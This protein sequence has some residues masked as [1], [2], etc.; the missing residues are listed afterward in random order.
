MRCIYFNQ[1]GRYT[2]CLPVCKYALSIYLLGIYF[3]PGTVLDTADSEE[4]EAA[5]L[6]LRWAFHSRGERRRVNNYSAIDHV[7]C[8]RDQ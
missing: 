3:L 2:T 6:S 4:N 7:L 5:M 8:A 1:I